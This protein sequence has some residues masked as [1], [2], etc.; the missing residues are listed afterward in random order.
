ME[1]RRQRL[2]EGI[3]K[4]I[5]TLLALLDSRNPNVRLKAAAEI[6]DRAGLIRSAHLEHTISPALQQLWDE[7]A[8]EEKSA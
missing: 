5:E 4:A 1:F 6:L 2:A 3:A 7:A 8:G